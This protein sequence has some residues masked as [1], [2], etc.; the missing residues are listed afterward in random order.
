MRDMT[1][2]EITRFLTEEGRMAT[3]ATVRADGRPHAVTVWFILDGEEV[4][5]T[6][7]HESVKVANLRRDGRLAL[8]V[9]DH[10]P[11]Y[12]YVTIEGVASIADD[13]PDLREWT[14]RIAARYMGD[15][16]AEEF[17]ARNGI[18]GELVVRVRPTHVIAKAGVF[19]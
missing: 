18:P 13:P 17:G 10:R 8:C 12:A 14:T 3:I 4:V 6:A 2:D 16:L 9:A 19:D 1:Q 7:W 15:A 5:F 11:P